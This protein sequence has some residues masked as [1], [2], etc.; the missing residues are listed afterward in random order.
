MIIQLMQMQQLLRYAKPRVI[1]S[2]PVVSNLW[3]CSSV[4]RAGKNVLFN[5]FLV[6][7]Y[8]PFG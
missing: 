5:F 2:S 8:G 7:F 6:V 3:R 4:G 1:G